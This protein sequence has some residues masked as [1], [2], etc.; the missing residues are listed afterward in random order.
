V[1]ARNTKLQGD[2]FNVVAT[3]HGSLF[4]VALTSKFED[5]IWVHSVISTL[6]KVIVSSG[7]ES[8]R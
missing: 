8:V 3:R 2:A 4:A 7:G 5:L 1:N 6:P